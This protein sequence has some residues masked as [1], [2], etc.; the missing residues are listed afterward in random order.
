MRLTRPLRS[1]GVRATLLRRQ[2]TSAVDA[3]TP[4]SHPVLD[5]PLPDSKEA[6]P[7]LTDKTTIS[8]NEVTRELPST[9]NYVQ[10]AIRTLRSEALSR[11]DYVV[12]PVDQE[13]CCIRDALTPPPGPSDPAMPD[14]N[15]S[16]S[17]L[18]YS[19]APGLHF[20]ADLRGFFYYYTPR[21]P[22]PRTAGEVRFRKMS[23]SQPWKFAA[24]ADLKLANGLPWCVELPTIAAF[25]QYR[26][27]RDILLRDGFVDEKTMKIAAEMGTARA[28]RK[29]TAPLIHGFG[30]PF[31]LNFGDKVHQWTFMGSERLCFARPVF[32]LTTFKVDGER[33]PP[34]WLGSAICTF[35][36]SKAPNHKNSRVINVSVVSVVDPFRRNP[37]FPEDLYEITPKPPRLNHIV[38]R[39]LKPWA[40]DVDNCVPRGRAE[41]FDVLFKNEELPPLRTNRLTGPPKESDHTG[42]IATDE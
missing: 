15:E 41:G 14:A 40:L 2:H 31:Y 12:F 10:P 9:A 18:R 3:V 28:Q 6:N 33:T 32:N 30:Q 23:S 22:A 21:G 27:L 17:K 8:P 38:R 24:G 39:A 36:K 29:K 16:F 20:P 35:T 42:E 7:G 4:S 34:P 19:D 13:Y 5:Q 25:D 1:L 37:D 26:A 11:S